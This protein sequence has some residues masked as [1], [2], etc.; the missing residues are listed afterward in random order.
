MAFASPS[1]WGAVRALLLLVLLAWLAPSGH[2]TGVCA[3]TGTLPPHVEMN[4]ACGQH[5]VATSVEAT[6]VVVSPQGSRAEVCGWA[7]VDDTRVSPGEGDC[8]R[9][10]FSLSRLLGGERVLP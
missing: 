5:H 4:S 9:V 3:D 8:A 10:Q 2:A 7:E 6:S 1:R